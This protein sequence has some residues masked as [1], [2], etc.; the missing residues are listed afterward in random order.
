MKVSFYADADPQVG[1]SDIIMYKV[2]KVK[3]YWFV[4]IKTQ[5]AYGTEQE[6]KTLAM[7][8]TKIYGTP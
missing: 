3:Q 5:I 6:M 4:K 8:L 1:D 2:I 7:N